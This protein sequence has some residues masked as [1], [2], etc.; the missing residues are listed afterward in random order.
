[1]ESGLRA[2]FIIGALTMLFAFLIIST[3]PEISIQDAAARAEQK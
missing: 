1:M 2:V 3:I